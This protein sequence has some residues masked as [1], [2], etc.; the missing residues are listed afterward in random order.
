MLRI[1]SHVPNIFTAANP[2]A[3]QRRP[4][5]LRVSCVCCFLAGPLV[6]RRVSLRKASHPSGWGGHPAETISRAALMLLLSRLA[7]CKSS[8]TSVSFLT[9]SRSH[10]TCFGA[11]ILVRSFLSSSGEARGGD[12][13]PGLSG[14][15][16]GRRSPEARAAS[17]LLPASVPRRDLSPPVQ[18]DPSPRVPLPGGTDRVGRVF[19]RLQQRS[20]SGPGAPAVTRSGVGDEGSCADR[21]AAGGSRIRQRVAGGTPQCSLPRLPGTHTQRVWHIPRPPIVQLVF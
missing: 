6:D 13:P 16:G 20:G 3:A 17:P 1:F 5:L 7:G 18:G 19:C 9:P 10:Q 14:R 12:P 11:K 21:R 15:C 4:A 8:M 2:W